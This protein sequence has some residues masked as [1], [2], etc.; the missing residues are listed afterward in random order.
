VVAFFDSNPDM[1]LSGY[2]L[3]HLF[4]LTNTG[5]TYLQAL[6]AKR[7][8]KKVALSTIYWNREKLGAKDF[9]LS[10]DYVEPFRYKMRRAR[11]ALLARCGLV[12][13]EK[14]EKHR[15][16]ALFY[17][18]GY[19][20]QVCGILEMTDMLL[21]NSEMEKGLILK[22]FPVARAKPCSVVV[23]GIDSALFDSRP[24]D[25]ENTFFEK[26]HMR[27]FVLCAGR[28]ERRKN[29]LRLLEAMKGVDVPLVLLGRPYDRKYFKELRE[30][31]RPFDR[32]VESWA[33]EKMKEVYSLARVHALPSYYETPGLASLEA[34]ALGLNIVVGNSGAESE[35][36]GPHAEYCE[37]TEVASIRSAL[38]KALSRD[39]PNKELSKHVKEH[40]T[41]ERAAMQTLEAYRRILGQSLT[42]NLV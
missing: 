29:Q 20:G 3:V 22:D 1:D 33:Y 26:Y 6:N 10:E 24:A 18:M 7:Q 34:G 40:F 17:Q 11:R 42:N 41:W 13:K 35:Y 2:D 32:V 16:D 25:G 36:F 8:G 30:L 38:E 14:M 15:R 9:S 31:F 27:D 23:N 12:K 21:P 5:D 37:P 39:A 4:N 19:H 28:I